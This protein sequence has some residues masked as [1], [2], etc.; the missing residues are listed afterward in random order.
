[1][2]QTKWRDILPPEA[3]AKGD[4]LFD[5]AAAERAKGK[6]IYPAQE[7]IFHA[8]QAVAPD[9]VKVVILGQDPYH[10]PGQAMGMSFSVPN[11]CPAPPS[12]QNI[13]KELAYEFGE[14]RPMANDLTPWTKQGVL[15]LNTA[16][17]VEYGQAFSHQ[18]WGWDILTGAV[19]EYCLRKQ[20]TVIFLLWGSPAA[21]T[22]KAA[23][24]RITDIPVKDKYFIFTTHPSPLSA[25]R[26]TATTHAFL[27]SM[28]F[29]TANRI[30]ESDGLAPIDWAGS[31]V[32]EA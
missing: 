21:K 26:S 31:L 7:N 12:L 9:D 19:T 6:I 2:S 18:D 22:A 29:T 16:L 14:N 27:Q 28:C 15:L 8:L 17:T 30:L 3:V 11:D 13:K 5:R 10:N 23:N 25:A 24:H 20:G 32:Q 4:E 1:M